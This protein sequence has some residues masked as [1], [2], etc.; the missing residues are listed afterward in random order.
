[1]T[2]FHQLEEVCMNSGMTKFHDQLPTW[3]K[4]HQTYCSQGLQVGLKGLQTFGHD[5][6][7]IPS[8]MGI[9]F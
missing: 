7:A 5:E 2:K 9:A 6:F 1:M 8:T 4:F 3:N